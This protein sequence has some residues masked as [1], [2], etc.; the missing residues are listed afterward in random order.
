MPD[1]P[2]CGGP[3]PR[4]VGGLCHGTCPAP[5]WL[6]SPLGQGRQCLSAAG[7]GP[8]EVQDQKSRKGNGSRR[9]RG[10]GERW[11]G[12]SPPGT[13]CPRVPL[14]RGSA[15]PKSKMAAAG[16]HASITR[17]GART[18]CQGLPPLPPPFPPP[19]NSSDQAQGML[20]WVCTTPPPAP[21]C[22]SRLETISDA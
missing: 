16:V 14:P 9:G 7:A 20:G 12:G 8:W 15:P 1:F 2:W 5:R 21:P 19:R 13:G 6:L 3:I 10:R 4:L 18:Q 11:E 22:A 17:V